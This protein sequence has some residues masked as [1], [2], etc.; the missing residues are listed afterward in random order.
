MNLSHWTLIQSRDFVLILW[1]LW[2]WSD[3]SITYFWNE[4]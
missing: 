1:K 2:G 3:S 4:T